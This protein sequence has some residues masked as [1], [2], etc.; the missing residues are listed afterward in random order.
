MHP[1]KN[2]FPTNTPFQIR[3]ENIKI[4]CVKNNLYFPLEILSVKKNLLYLQN[5]IL[6]CLR[7]K[8]ERS[9]KQ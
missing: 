4:I 5:I 1:A 3:L 9:Q 7:N 6:T 2:I 8:Q